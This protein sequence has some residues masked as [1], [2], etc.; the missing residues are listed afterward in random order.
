MKENSNESKIVKGAKRIRRR[1]WC[2]RG[3]L[4]NQEIEGR[5]RGGEKMKD[6]DKNEK[7]EGVSEGV[8]ENKE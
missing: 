7:M 8:G 5:R 4:K 1:L 6:R 2:E 3:R